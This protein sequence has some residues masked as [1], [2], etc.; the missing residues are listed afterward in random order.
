MA[1]LNKE[2]GEFL[3][4]MGKLF[5]ISDVRG[6][7]SSP[8]AEIAF[9]HAADV[10]ARAKGTTEPVR[11]E[12]EDVS[13]QIYPLVNKLLFLFVHMVG[14]QEMYTHYV[15][16]ITPDGVEFLKSTGHW[17]QGMGPLARVN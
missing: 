6:W 12:I 4:E 11:I 8:Y 9:Q 14:G 10:F 16:E 1:G 13:V 15:F 2:V 17:P 3:P 5:T 7:L